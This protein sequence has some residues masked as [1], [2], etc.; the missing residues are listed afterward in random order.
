MNTNIL[1]IL[2]YCE[3]FISPQA[4]NFFYFLNMTHDFWF[5]N[6]RT[7]RSICGCMSAIREM[8]SK[9]VSGPMRMH[10]FLMSTLQFIIN[11]GWN[12]KKYLAH[13]SF[14]TIT[15][16]HYIFHSNFLFTLIT[17]D[18]ILPE[19][20]HK[21]WRQFGCEGETCIW[22][23]RV[24]VRGHLWW[25]HWGSAVLGWCFPSLGSHSVSC[26]TCSI[27][28]SRMERERERE[29]YIYHI[30][31]KGFTFLESYIWDLRYDWKFKSL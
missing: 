6:R 11:H 23:H 25:V 31:N 16:E 12:L 29:S 2:S 3:V 4:D 20:L 19:E 13:R 21:S 10:S 24:H 14:D 5:H 15:T 1:A 7:C 30:D 17:S 27:P 28:N 9:I 18:F 22:W 8:F 26:R